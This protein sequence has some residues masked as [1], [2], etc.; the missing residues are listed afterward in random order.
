MAPQY[1]EARV[2]YITYTTGVVPNEGNATAYVSGLINNPTFS[3]N[4]IIEGNATINGNLNVSGDINASGVVISGITGLFDDGT[5]AAPSIAFASDPNTGIYNPT[6]NEIGFSTGGVERVRIDNT[7]NVGIGTSIAYFTPTS[8]VNVPL[9]QTHS[10]N[11]STAQCM[12][13]SWATGTNVGANLSLC[14]SDSG[15]IGTYSPAIGSSDVLGNVRFNGSDGTKFIEGARITASADGTWATDDGPTKLVFST[16]ADGA[17]SP[18]ERLRIDSSGNVGIGTSSP[19]NLLHILDSSSS[20]S[21][22]ANL[23]IE[24][25][26][27]K[28]RFQDRSG[29]SNS[30]EISGDNALIFSVSPP[31]D[32]NTNLTEW[33]RITANGNVGIGTSSPGNK[34]SVVGQANAT[35]GFTVGSEDDNSSGGIFNAGS[36][37]NSMTVEADPNNVGGNSK[38]EF[39]LDG[40][41]VIT[42][43]QGGNVGIGTT[44]PSAKLHVIDTG[45]TGIRS[46]SGSAQATDSNKALHVSNGDTTDTFNVSYKGQGYF[47]GNVGIGTNSPL[48]ELEVVG[49]I[50]IRNG[51]QINAIR[52]N[53]DGQLQFM[54]NAAANDTVTVTIDDETGN[55]GIGTTSPSNTLDVVSTAGVIG[56][57]ST[58]E[59]NSAR[60]NI[61]GGTSSYAG[62]NFGDSDALTIGYAR[63]YNS[64]D[65]LRFQTNGSERVRI[66][67]DGV[68]TVN[69]GFITLNGNKLGAVKI[70]IDDSSFA[71]ITPPRAGC[72]YVTVVEGGDEQYPNLNVR[73]FLYADWNIS[74]FATGINLGS[75]FEVST[76]GPPNGDTGALGHVTLFTGGT[77]GELYLENR[78]GSAG[79]FFI[80]FI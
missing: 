54:R 27:P 51:D 52:T 66:E 80:N 19:T 49:D 1:G 70:E 17:S 38:L 39:K 32:D 55:V 14:R 10:T 78:L 21:D 37:S 2:D 43:P 48:T 65:S 5:E 28:I 16:T 41:T 30:C 31:V 61:K 18:T 57:T 13:T 76:A 71:T 7:G 34:L 62:I 11:A 73:G 47:A 8:T 56:I 12:V 33:M 22:Q 69:S 44:D 72:G 59:T 45:A 79:I 60:I 50:T 20:A 58:T 29:S 64:D 42:I 9:L 40:S 15:T 25:F 26:R 74:P 23:K 6:A 63:Y 46:Q 35:T 3:G 75:L 77:D 53:A 4:V 36:T 67:S 24:A 68:V